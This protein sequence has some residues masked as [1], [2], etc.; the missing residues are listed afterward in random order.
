MSWSETPE[1]T[2]SRPS[3]AGGRRPGTKLVATE[4]SSSFASGKDIPYTLHL[5]AAAG[6]QTRSSA[7]LC[8]QSSADGSSPEAPSQELQSEE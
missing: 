3:R 7:V 8:V 6:I 4:L 5:R 2:V 1:R